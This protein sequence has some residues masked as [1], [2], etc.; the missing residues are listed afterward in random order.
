MTIDLFT[1]DTVAPDHFGSDTAAAGRPRRASP[2]RE[3]ARRAGRATP[4]APPTPQQQVGFQ[5]GW[6]HAHHAI[7]PAA[8]HALEASPVHQGWLAGQA[9]F[10]PRTLADTAPVRQWLALR[11]HA[12]QQQRHVE[13]MHITPAYLRQLA[14]T[15]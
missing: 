4:I 5:L 6:D 1:P 15:H 8:P 3:V 7:T 11:L 9:V 10:G 14:V 13:L 12:W 2:V